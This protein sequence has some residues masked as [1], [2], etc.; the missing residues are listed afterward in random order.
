[1]GTHRLRPIY[2]SKFRTWVQ[3]AGYK[4]ELEFW[5]SLSGISK[6]TVVDHMVSY[7]TSQGYRGT[8]DDQFASFLRAQT[9]MNGTIFDMGNQ[10]F[11]GTFSVVAGIVDDSGNIIRDDDGNVVIDGS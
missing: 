11:D 2:P 6:G 3:R 9:S 8:P 5:S 10:F 4:T 7:L 1:M